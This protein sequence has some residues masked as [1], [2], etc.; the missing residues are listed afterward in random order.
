MDTDDRIQ[1]NRKKLIPAHDRFLIIDGPD[2]NHFGGSL[3]DLY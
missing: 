3:K 2:L 1:Y